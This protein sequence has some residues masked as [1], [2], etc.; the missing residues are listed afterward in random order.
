MWFDP[1]IIKFNAINLSHCQCALFF[2][3]SLVFSIYLSVRSL[4]LFYSSCLL[5]HLSL[6]VVIVALCIQLAVNLMLPLSLWARVRKICAP[7]VNFSPFQ[8]FHSRVCVCVCVQLNQSWSS[9]CN[10]RPSEKERISENDGMKQWINSAF[11]FFPFAGKPF[12]QLISCATNLLRLH[13][14]E[15]ICMLP[16]TQQS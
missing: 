16:V 8:H 14:W 15:V 5:F 6:V 11:E 12:R 13:C 3:L 2:S 9:V 10:K 1:L 7:G 4:Y